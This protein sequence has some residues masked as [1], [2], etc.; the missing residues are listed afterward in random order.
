MPSLP[1]YS[2]YRNGQRNMVQSMYAPLINILDF[3][4]LENIRGLNAIY[5][6]QTWHDLVCYA[7]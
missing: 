4:I 6:H 5:E 7:D 1:P 3:M 2:L